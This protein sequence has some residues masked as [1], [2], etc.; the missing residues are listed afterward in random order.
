MRE[1]NKAGVQTIR[2]NLEAR[3]YFWASGERPSDADRCISAGFG[4]TREKSP[5]WIQVF[6]VS[7]GLPKNGQALIISQQH[8][9]TS[10]M[11]KYF[12]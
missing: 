10:Q 2:D 8:Q 9:R 3:L 1:R 4:F 12:W 7:K 6:K 5:A 11:K